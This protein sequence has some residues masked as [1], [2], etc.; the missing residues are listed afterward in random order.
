MPLDLIPPPSPTHPASRHPVTPGGFLLQNSCSPPSSPR[1]IRPVTTPSSRYWSPGDI[2]HRSLE[3]LRTLD[4]VTGQHAVAWAVMDVT[5]AGYEGYLGIHYIFKS[6]KRRR[7]DTC[8]SARYRSS[9]M[10]SILLPRREW[11]WLTEVF[12]FD[13]AAARRVATN[14]ELTVDIDILDNRRQGATPVT[15]AESRRGFRYLRLIHSHRLVPVLDWS[16]P[17]LLPIRRH[18]T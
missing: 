6:R 15:F 10:F 1:S 9:Q 4:A 5:D 13:A 14:Q 8:T 16:E 3:S 7:P 2:L 12:F 18:V 17:F 11:R